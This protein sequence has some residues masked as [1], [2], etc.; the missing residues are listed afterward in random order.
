MM[1]FVFMAQDIYI[2]MYV[3]IFAYVN[4]C[5]VYAIYIYT[6]KIANCYFS[7]TQ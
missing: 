2:Y 6:I 3:C 7:Q 5:M 1:Q 4:V